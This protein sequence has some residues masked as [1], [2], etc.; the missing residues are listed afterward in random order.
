MES[1]G[2]EGSRTAFDCVLGA[3]KAHERELRG[4]LLHRLGDRYLA[5]DMLQEILL[6]AMRQGEGFCVLDSPRAWLF[7]V[8][9]NALVDHAR[10]A[11]PT[12]E[13]PDT[14]AAE[15]DERVPVDALDACLARNLAALAAEDRDVIEQCDLRGTRRQEYA[16]A[17]GLTLAAVK[18]RLLRARARLRARLVEHCRV[19]FDEAGRVCCHVA[20]GVDA[21]G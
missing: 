19:R 8:A 5:D 11:K 9:R 18:S 15:A 17:R 16:A 12:V 14:L 10:L 2:Q 6:K 4:Y 21:P 1:R 20:P 7:Q 13:L 3:W